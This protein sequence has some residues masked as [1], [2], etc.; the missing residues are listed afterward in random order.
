[1]PVY[2]HSRLETFESCPLKYRFRYID[3]IEK[4]GVQTVEAFLGNRVHEALKK[5]YD[6]LVQASR[7]TLDDLLEFYRQRWKQEWGPGITIVAARRTQHDYLMDGTQCI[8]NYYDKHE[9]FDHC[10]TIATEQRIDFSL[11]ASGRYSMTGYVDRIDR[12]EDGTY[13]IHDYK[14]SKTVPRQTEADAS[15]QLGLYQLGVQKSRQGARKVELNW[16]Y[17]RHGV[18][19]R[20]TR[21][22]QQLTR[23]CETTAALIDRIEAEKRFPP[24]KGRLCDWCE[25]KPDCPEWNP[26]LF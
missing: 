6:D 26:S 13:E 25:Y 18:T 3:K 8:Q 7:N 4:P 12:R 22:P 9:P 24:N 1:M 21:S 15:R 23:L 10:R 11:D 19:L 5:L 2:S 17:L 16:H 14:T 20:S